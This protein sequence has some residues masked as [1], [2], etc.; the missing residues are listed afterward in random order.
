MNLHNEGVTMVPYPKD[1]KQAVSDAA[2]A[3]QEFLALPQAKKDALEAAD[4]HIGS[5]YERKGNGRR[6]SSDRK[7]NFDLTRNGISELRRRGNKDTEPLLVASE[8]LLNTLEPA[9]RDFVA[10]I[11]DTYSLDSLIETARQ[12]EK[13]R[14][15]RFLYYPSIKEGTTIGEAHTDHSGYTFHLYESTG[16]CHGLA[17]DKNSWFDM[18]VAET[19][20]AAFAGMQLQLMSKGKL[21]ALCHKISANHATSQSGRIAIVCFNL[22]DGMPTYDRKTHGRLQEKT[23]GFNYSMPFDEFKVLFT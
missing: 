7:E 23:P 5:G 17:F 18:P 6:E 9:A 2:V 1:V 12:S 16:G 11:A 19:E 4:L 13:N 21:R 10:Q 8:Q 3:W 15:V 14:F 20:M 22:L